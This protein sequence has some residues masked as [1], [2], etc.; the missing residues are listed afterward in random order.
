MCMIMIFIYRVSLSG[1]NILFLF[2]KI[3]SRSTK[4]KLGG[5]HTPGDT[6][7]IVFRKEQSDPTLN[8]PPLF[9]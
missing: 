8:H 7:M 5:L 1:F 2:W 9:F 3:W 6:D 4:S